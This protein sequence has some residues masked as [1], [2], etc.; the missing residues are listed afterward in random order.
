MWPCL[1]CL[2]LCC[3]Q[4]SVPTRQSNTLSL[5]YDCQISWDWF[6]PRSWLRRLEYLVYWTAIGW[7]SADL[8]SYWFIVSFMQY[9][10]EAVSL[11]HATGLTSTIWSSVVRVDKKQACDWS[12]LANV[13]FWL[14]DKD[15]DSDTIWGQREAVTPGAAV[16][17][18]RLAGECV[19]WHGDNL[20]WSDPAWQEKHA[21]QWKSI[22]V[23]LQ[24]VL[25][26]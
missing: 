25:V 15:V 5:L 9:C 23:C 1:L 11:G 7:L 17:G 14:V 24:L 26:F 18:P 4:L 19:G 2:S 20:Q 3:L 13:R 6:Y 12:V 22:E 10:L 16:A 8:Y 21:T